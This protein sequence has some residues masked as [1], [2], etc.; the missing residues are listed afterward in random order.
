MIDAYIPIIFYQVNGISLLTEDGQ[1]VIL[2]MQVSL[3]N[4]Q[5]MQ[6]KKRDYLTLNMEILVI[7]PAGPSGHA[8]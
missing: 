2:L 7:K 5:E 6:I 4:L 8:M 1:N 3:V